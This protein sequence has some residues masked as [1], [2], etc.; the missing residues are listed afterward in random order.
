MTPF[1]N[2]ILAAL[3]F[4]VPVFHV[5]ASTALSKSQQSDPVPDIELL[6]KASLIRVTVIEAHDATRQVAFQKPAQRERVRAW[7]LQYAW[8]PV[9]LNTIG[10]VQGRGYFEVFTRSTDKNP[11]LTIHIFGSKSRAEPENVHVTKENWQKFLSLLP[12][13]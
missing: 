5:A 7:I 11:A 4:I 10:S 2:S 12:P 6:R 1:A 3:S 13:K 8:P 9:D